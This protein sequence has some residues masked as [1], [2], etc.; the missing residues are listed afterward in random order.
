MLQKTYWLGRI[1]DEK[2]EV[3][4]KIRMLYCVHEFPVGQDVQCSPAFTIT[5]GGLVSN[6]YGW[7]LVINSYSIAMPGFVFVSVDEVGEQIR[8]LLILKLNFLLAKLPTEVEKLCDIRNSVGSEL[9]PSQVVPDFFS[10]ERKNLYQTIKGIG[11]WINAILLFPRDKY[12]A[13]LTALAAYERSFYVLSA[14]PALSYALLVFAIE[15]LANNHEGYQASWS[16]IKGK[17]GQRLNSLFGDKRISEVNSCWIEEF[18]SAL[19]DILHP[20]ATK[21]FTQFALSHIDNRFFD[22]SQSSS[23]SPLRQTRLKEGI[24]NAYDIRSSF[25]HALLPLNQRLI[26]ESRRA[27]ELEHEGHV[28]IT[29]RGM[30]RITR[31]ILLKFIERQTNV[32]PIAE[33]EKYIGDWINKTNA[34]TVQLSRP[35]AYTRIKDL[36]SN[37]SPFEIEDS[38]RCLEDILCIYQENYIEGFHNKLEKNGADAETFIGIATSGSHTGRM[39]FRSDPNPSYDWK[40]TEK[41]SLKL[42][43][44]ANQEN[45]G[46]LQAIA[47]ISNV[48]GKIDGKDSSWDS[49]LKEGRFGA[50]Q[51][52][53]ARFVVDIINRNISDWSAEQA[54]KAVR[55]HLKKP[56]I[57]IPSRVEI[58]CLLQV[59]SLFDEEES[60]E[61]KLEWLDIAYGDTAAYPKIQNLIKNWRLSQ[62]KEIDPQLILNV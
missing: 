46:Y 51:R 58:A 9:V 28:Y 59:A 26:S 35:P 21:R 52:K 7:A 40:V 33:P 39:L 3:S 56:K 6:T 10:N 17:S 41:H 24:Q 27:E 5:D 43:P 62:T 36:N 25:A 37:F 12:D 42:I 2:I 32:Y 16:D 53:I 57:Y 60:R 61:G 34:G 44:N 22:A 11:P 45:K 8:R 1:Q 47:L 49:V 55:E 48:L 38:K 23:K 50:P 14:D 29:L 18:K 20:A 13:L 4:Q 30:F 19:V 54:E 31:F 15:A